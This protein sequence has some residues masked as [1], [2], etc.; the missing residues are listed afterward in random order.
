ML[1][2]ADRFKPFGGLVKSKTFGA[3]PAVQTWDVTSGP[4]V[5]SPS[6][7]E[8]WYTRSVS[9]SLL[10]ADQIT[11]PPALAILILAAVV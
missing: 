8:Q 11:H 10:I 1:V 4:L 2:A 7:D 9:I 6:K 3:S 5:F